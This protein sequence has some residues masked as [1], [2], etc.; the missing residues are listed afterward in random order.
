VL[1]WQKSAWD[2]YPED[3]VEELLQRVHDME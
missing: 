1:M 3:I 2:K